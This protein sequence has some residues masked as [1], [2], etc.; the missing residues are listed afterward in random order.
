M[1]KNDFLIMHAIYKFFQKHVY[2]III[3]EQLVPMQL[4]IDTLAIYY[5]RKA[6]SKT[7]S[8]FM[9]YTDLVRI[10]ELFPLWSEL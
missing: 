2:D 4:R 10:P 9:W 3:T 5:Y 1:L 6:S 8:I 7:R